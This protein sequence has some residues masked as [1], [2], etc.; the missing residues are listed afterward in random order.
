MATGL[1]GLEITPA[2]GR[3]VNDLVRI[4]SGQERTVAEQP[5]NITIERSY[6]HGDSRAGTRRGVAL[7][8]VQQQ[9]SW[10]RT[11]RIAKRWTWI[12]RQSPDGTAQVRTSSATHYLEASGENIMF[13]GADPAVGGAHPCKHQ[14]RG[15]SSSEPASWKVSDPPTRGRTGP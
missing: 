8:G 10:T 6:L 13:G 15:K 1:A 9:Q 12:H 2:P 3:Y 4:G 14:D 5:Q 11:F 7:N